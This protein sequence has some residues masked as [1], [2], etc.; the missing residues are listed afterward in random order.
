MTENAEA[1]LLANSKFYRALSLANA[2]MM[3][4]QWIHSESATCNHPGWHTLTGFETIQ[5]SWAVIFVNQGPLHVW[6]TEAEVTFEGD[7][8]WVNCVENIDATN[9]EAN[10][11]VCMRAR[12]AFLPTSD[13]WKMLHHTAEPL[14]GHEFQAVNQRLAPN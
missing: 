1:V 5:Q 4:R 11:I 10:K 12:N 3:R 13:G 7:L 14:P 6:P 8:A 9:T 2:S